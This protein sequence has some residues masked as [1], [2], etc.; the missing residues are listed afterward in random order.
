M[1]WAWAC[2][3]S[4]EAVL[5]CMQSSGAVLYAASAA[6]RRD[7]QLWGYLIA[8]PGQTRWQPRGTRSSVSLRGVAVGAEPWPWPLCRR[9][10]G[11]GSSSSALWMLAL[12]MKKMGGGR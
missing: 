5:V 7:M 8:W 1:G 10:G 9:L 4:P 11:V 2:S 12:V 3:S 6:A